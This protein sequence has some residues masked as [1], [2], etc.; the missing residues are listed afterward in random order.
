MARVIEMHSQSVAMTIMNLRKSTEDMNVAA[1]AAARAA[2]AVLF[3]RV[4]K[5]AMH[6]DHSLRDLAKLDHPYARRHGRIIKIHQDTPHVVHMRSGTL[7]R[8]LKSKAFRGADPGYDVYFDGQAPWIKFVIQ[9]T[10]VMLPRNLIMDTA[11]EPATRAEMFR[12]VVRV[13]GKGLRSQA[14][15]RPGSIA[16]LSAPLGG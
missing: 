12:T 7:L 11:N 15:V 4:R 5:N 6:T 2:G 16:G 3:D 10:R 13:L 8:A 1:Y 14:V 9:G